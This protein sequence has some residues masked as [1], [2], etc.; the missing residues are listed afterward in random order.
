[1]RNSKAH[2]KTLGIALTAA[3][4][5]F[6]YPA[7][8]QMYSWKDPNTGQSKF[9][10]IPPP[11]YSRGESVSG[12]RVTMTLGGKVVDDTALPYQDRLLLSGKSRDQ[13]ESSRLQKT[14]ETGPRQHRIA[15]S[16]KPDSQFAGRPPADTT[17]PGMGAVGKKGS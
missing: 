2:S 15:Q 3:F 14:P 17:P 8:A 9:S 13:I 16:A 11:W 5:L 7:H 4:L 12:P 6:S 10:N 1:M